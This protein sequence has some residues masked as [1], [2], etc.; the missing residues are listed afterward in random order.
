MV[1]VVVGLRAKNE[2]CTEATEEG[3]IR[4]CWLIHQLVVGVAIVAIALSKVA[5][6]A[7]IRI[8]VVCPTGSAYCAPNCVVS[9]ETARD[10]SVG[11]TGFDWLQVLLLVYL[12]RVKR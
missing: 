3:G 8:S 11:S 1:Q 2:Q 4:Q 6:M 10:W 5:I 7:T 9:S 12:T